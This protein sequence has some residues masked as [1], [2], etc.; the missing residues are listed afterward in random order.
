MVDRRQRKEDKWYFRHKTFIHT[1]TGIVAGWYLARHLPEVELISFFGD[2]IVWL[3]GVVRGFGGLAIVASTAL[4][5]YT[6]YD[7][8]K[9]RR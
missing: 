4:T 6:L 7:K 3:T 5:I 1:V 8:I 2:S 9:K